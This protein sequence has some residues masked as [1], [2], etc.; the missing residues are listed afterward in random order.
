MAQ[1]RALLLAVV[2]VVLG[3][4]ATAAAPSTGLDPAQRG[5]LEALQAARVALD[6]PRITDNQRA[7]RAAAILRARA[8]GEQEAIRLLEATP[9]GLDIARV[10]LDTS[11]A[12]FEIAARDPD[13]QASAM[14]LRNILAEPR[15]H[16]DQGPLAAIFRAVNDIFKTIFQSLVQPGLVQALLLIVLVVI[17]ALVVI[18]L[19][20]SLR[21]PL[22]RGRRLGGG[23]GADDDPGVPEY[24]RTA[25]ALAQAGDFAGAVR[26]LAAGTMELVSGERSFT[27]SPLTV[28]ETFRRSGQMEALRPLLRAFESSYYGH[29][30]TVLQDYVTA[31][32]AAA[33][34]RRIAAAE[35][36]A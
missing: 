24:F 27:A 11:I 36:A 21:Q 18:F 32:E 9:P 33:A 35:V 13:P 12:G 4:L 23:P 7:S 17:V 1:V 29:Y 28:R 14:R 34:Y 10:R 30:E 5:H 26:A 8:E 19:M 2:L 20:P 16:P 3:T 6:T 31:A 22:L 15:F 25:E